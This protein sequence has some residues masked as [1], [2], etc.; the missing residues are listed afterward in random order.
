MLSESSWADAEAYA[1]TLGGHLATIETLDEN[2]FLFSTF[3]LTVGGLSASGKASMWIGLNDAAQE[4]QYV[5]SSGSTSAFRNWNSGQPQNHYVDEDYA[6]ILV[7][8]F[9]TAGKWHDVVSD[10]RLGDVTFGIV[11][12]QAVPVPSAFWLFG[13]GIAGLLGMKRR[14]VT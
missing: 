3:G 4:G 14:K 8:N 11:E 9:G 6:A 2:N 10:K 5:W 7:E 12:L 1:Q 13:S